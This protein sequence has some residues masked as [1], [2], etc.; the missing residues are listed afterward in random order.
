MKIEINATT[1]EIVE[2]ELTDAE[3]KQ[4]T[5]DHAEVKKINAEKSAEALLLETQKQAVLD[6]L[7]ISAEEAKLLLS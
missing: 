2:R 7:G 4:E 5:K 3:I 6:R 1:G